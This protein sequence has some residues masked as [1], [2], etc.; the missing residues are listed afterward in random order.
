MLC[1]IIEGSPH[2]VQLLDSRMHELIL[3]IL[4]VHLSE[5]VLGCMSLSILAGLVFTSISHLLCL[6]RLL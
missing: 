3:V 6:V 4:G 1:Q 5:L 2:I